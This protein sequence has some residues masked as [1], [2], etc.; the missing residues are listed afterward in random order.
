MNYCKKEIIFKL[1]FK[2]Y[3]LYRGLE[4]LI[5]GNIIMNMLLCFG[6]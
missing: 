4:Y 3:L 1:F 2:F 6:I 5:V